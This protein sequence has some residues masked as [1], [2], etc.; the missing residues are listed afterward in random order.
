M[1]P[2][3]VAV[4]AQ[5]L[6]QSGWT[7]SAISR[8]VGHD[9]KTVRI[10]LTGKRDPG[11]PRSDTRDLF[12]PFSAYA[13]LRVRH[14]PHLAASALHDE[15]NALG[16]TGS[17]SAL[18]RS[19]RQRDLLPSCPTCGQAPSPEI[20]RRASPLNDL[21]PHQGLP[22]RVAPLPG[23]T[24]ASY[25]QNL[26]EA[27]H[28]PAAA[29]LAHLSPWFRTQYRAHDDLRGQ[30]RVTP[31]DVDSLARLTRSDPDALLQALPALAARTHHSRPPVRLTT[32]CRRCAARRGITTAV[33]VHLTA[34][35]RLCHRH[36]T[37]LG[38]SQQID[39]TNC[40][41]ITRSAYRAARLALHHPPGQILLAETSAR[42]IIAGW[43]R[44]DRH[45]NL[46]RRW[47]TLV[48]LINPGRSHPELETLDT[49]LTDAATYSQTVTLAAAFLS[50][51]TW[52]ANAQQG[53]TDDLAAHLI[54]SL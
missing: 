21:H 47:L 38:Q 45:P 19:L 20:T 8:R 28:L 13:T 5:E 11:T 25:L 32:A 50:S 48:G 31:A 6:H 39:T 22:V 43:L 2:A 12:A 18:T 36:H 35:H 37:W 9:R 24:I 17:Y 29:L 44:E 40:P 34:L 1:I 15:L 16:Y 46:T 23:Q 53:R 33:P 54:E 26:A 7:V 30:T 10:Y 42:E 51:P 4:L 49:D 52:A 27:N 14:D 3:H 41:D